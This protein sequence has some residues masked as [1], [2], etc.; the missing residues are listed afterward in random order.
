MPTCDEIK[1]AVIEYN[2]VN[3]TEDDAL[4]LALASIQSPPRSFGRVLAEVCLIADWGSINLTHFPFYERVAMAREI[5]ACG[6]VLQPMQSWHLDNLDA[7][8]TKMLTDAVEQ[9]FSHTS[10]LQPPQTNRRQLSFLSK[11]LH[12]RVNAAFPIWDGNA[13]KALNCRDDDRSWDSYIGWLNCVRP[14]ALEHK[15]CCLEHVRVPGE[16]LLRTFDKALYMLG[17]PT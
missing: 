4:K 16:C 10:L 13:R 5:E 6:S 15:D 11:Y 2:T 1:K 12:W 14:K 7:A 3:P 17:Q 8:E 9:Q